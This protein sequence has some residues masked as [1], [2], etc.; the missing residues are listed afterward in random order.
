MAREL[1]AVVGKDK[2][3]FYHAGMT[4]EEKKAVESWYFDKTD[5]IL[6][7]TCAYGMGVD[8]KNIRTIIH[9]QASPTVESY[10]QEAG[11][12]ARDGKT[13]NAIL[14][15]SYDDERNA[16][17]LSDTS[18]QKAVARFAQSTTCRRQ[19]LLDALGA[20][21]AVCEGCD[22]CNTGGPSPF[23][24]DA[25]FVFSYVKSHR[26]LFDMDQLTANL[27]TLLNERDRKLAS[28]NIW[29]H[30]DA[31]EIVREL[32]A[33]KY[34][35]KCRFPWKGKITFQKPLQ[36]GQQPVLLQRERLL[37]LLR[38]GRQRQQA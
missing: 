31:E 3:R 8:K 11:R 29:E 25:A 1:A 12:G 21:Q 33:A 2:V 34:I 27:I 23:A 15:W 10:I 24:Q 14:L 26:K 35:K 9:T 38:R 20:E 18:R 19:V 17:R 13:A 7:A 36:Q 32:I 30:S 6:C 22:V 4:K 16:K 37:H 5:A 28:V